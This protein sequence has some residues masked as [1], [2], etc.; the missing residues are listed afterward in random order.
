M[1]GSGFVYSIS[2]A[3][4]MPPLPEVMLFAVSP[5]DVLDPN[6]QVVVEW[7][8]RG[9]ARVTIAVGSTLL[10]DQPA[11]GTLTF[12]VRDIMAG[13]NP[14]DIW[15]NAQDAQ[16]NSDQE[17]LRIPLL[18]D[19]RIDSFTA[20]PAAVAPGGEVTLS[21]SASGSLASGYIYWTTQPRP[22]LVP[23]GDV[24][25]PAGVLTHTLPAGVYGDTQAYTL[26]LTD[27]NGVSISQTATV[28]VV[29]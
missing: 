16:N 7:R 18:T 6:G 28:T 8:T 1:S 23:V 19:L 9:A 27:V 17:T 14:V 26:V 15:V 4:A 21:W 25:T 10:A 3:G 11:A 2:P 20:S 22:S 29:R 13:T 12:A 5:S 24:V